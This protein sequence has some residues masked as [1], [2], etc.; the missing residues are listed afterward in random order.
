MVGALRFRSPDLAGQ[1]VIRPLFVFVAPIG[2][3]GMARIHTGIGLC[4]FL[5]SAGC[6]N[7]TT[8]PGLLLRLSA[9]GTQRRD[10]VV[11]RATVTNESTH[12][13]SWDREFSAHLQWGMVNALGQT[14]AWE[15][16]ANLS[17]PPA[18]E[19]ANRF[20]PCN[21]VSHWRTTLS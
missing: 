11:V 3:E 21:R 15:K 6:A 8:P 19:F 13:V 20:A 9:V 10:H 18:S 5:L 17:K 4:A 12:A 2:S 1:A 16:L 14:L 7:D